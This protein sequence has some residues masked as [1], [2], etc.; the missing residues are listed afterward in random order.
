[1]KNKFFLK[2]ITLA[3]LFS[4]LSA[5][6]FAK[7]SSWSNDLRSKF[8]A[9]DSVIYTINIRTFGAVDTNGNDIIE[10]LMNQTF[11]HDILMLGILFLLIHHIIHQHFF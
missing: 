5:P 3:L 11:L 2:G 4:F 8:I 6:G 7:I 10:P 1:M 9:N